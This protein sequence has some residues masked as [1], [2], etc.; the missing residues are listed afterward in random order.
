MSRSPSSFRRAWVVLGGMIV[1]GMGAFFLAK[2]AD[3]TSSSAPHGEGPGGS[4]DRGPVPR[5]TGSGRTPLSAAAGAPSAEHPAEDV[6]ASPTFRLG[7]I[8]PISGAPQ[9][10]PEQPGEIVVDPRDAL[11]Q[12]AAGRRL[13]EMEHEARAIYRRMQSV[14]GLGLTSEQADD[15]M[16]LEPMLQEIH[17]QRDEMGLPTFDI[18]EPAESGS[19][20]APAR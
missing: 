5:P 7:T 6:Q 17:R 9:G 10:A 12:S 18:D 3:E 19:V 13:A 2:P 1:V 20:S 16:R 14:G 11:R 4:A 15:K 8:P